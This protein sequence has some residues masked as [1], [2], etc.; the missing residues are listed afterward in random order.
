M[1][2]GNDRER[3]RQN[4]ENELIDRIDEA[5]MR[6]SFISTDKPL[7]VPMVEMLIFKALQYYRPQQSIQDA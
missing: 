7:K 5:Q 3:E 6:A 1:A 4:I 2:K